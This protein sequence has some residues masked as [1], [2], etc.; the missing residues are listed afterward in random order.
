MIRDLGVGAVDTPAVLLTLVPRTLLSADVVAGPAVKLKSVRANQ[1]R[2]FNGF[3]DA[4][5]LR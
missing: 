5:D 2:R 4:V 3:L 1:H